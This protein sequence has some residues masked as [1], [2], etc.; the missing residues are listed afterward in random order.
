MILFSSNIKKFCF[1]LRKPSTEFKKYSCSLQELQA[2][3]WESDSLTLFLTSHLLSL[4][5][6]GFPHVHF[7]FLGIIHAIPAVM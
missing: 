4:W 5:M 1:V 6:V 2:F 3:S 7:Y